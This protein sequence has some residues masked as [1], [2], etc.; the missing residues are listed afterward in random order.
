MEDIRTRQELIADSI[1]SLHALQ[2]LIEQ[3]G[4]AAPDT[5]PLPADE[6][7]EAYDEG[8]SKGYGAHRHDIFI[9]MLISILVAGGAGIVIG[10][11][12]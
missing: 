8:F 2:A 4:G 12:I 1:E 5:P 11:A 9:P 6:Y 10:R 3:A 7:H